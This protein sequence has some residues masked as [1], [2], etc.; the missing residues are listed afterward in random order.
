MSSCASP[1]HNLDQMDPLLR[2][3]EHT[4]ACKT[5]FDSKTLWERYGIIGNVTAS[6]VLV[7][8]IH[9]SFPYSS[10]QPFTDNFPRADIY[11]LITPDLLH[12]LIK[13]VFKDHLV[14]WVC[15]YLEHEHGKAKANTIL[16][17]IDRQ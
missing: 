12:Q 3:S 16:D 5:A 2:S 15:E 17:E 8:S 11:E 13:G 7:P 14:D 10:A 1:P 9:G 4:A 6:L